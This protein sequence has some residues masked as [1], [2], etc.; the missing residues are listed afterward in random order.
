MTTR[1][2]RFGREFLR[3]TAQSIA[4][5]TLGLGIGALA[6]T[7]FGALGTRIQNVGS[8]ALA[9]A[10]SAGASALTR[11]KNAGKS[12]FLSI[13]NAGKSFLS[14]IKNV[15]KVDL[16]GIKKLARDVFNN[17]NPFRAIRQA[18]AARARI[19]RQR[20]AVN[21]QIIQDRNLAGDIITADVKAEEDT[22]IF[23]ETEPGPRRTVLT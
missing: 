16:S 21:Q 2:S 11:S 20:E 1:L 10:R 22:G 12:G 9:A 4:L 5:G 19:R 15:G 18:R 8:S 7:D 3:Q 6:T 14:T 17:L 23:R 13:K